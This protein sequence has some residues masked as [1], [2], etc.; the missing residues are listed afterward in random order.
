MQISI[1]RAEL[2]RSEWHDFGSRRSGF[3]VT[4]KAEVEEESHKVFLW[5]SGN[6]FR[7]DVT[8]TVIIMP[9]PWATGTFVFLVLEGIMT[10]KVF[11]GK[12]THF[13]EATLTSMLKP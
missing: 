12:T 9:F 3:A 8:R 11:I 5:T 4:V 13:I 6:R 7:P 10:S 1:A 2:T